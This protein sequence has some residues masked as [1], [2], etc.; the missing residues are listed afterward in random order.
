MKLFT[1]DIL[2]ETPAVYG[3]RKCKGIDLN[4]EIDI[5]VVRLIS[6]EDG[7]KIIKNHQCL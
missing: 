2:K 1:K 7:L 6:I 3:I 4:K 5:L